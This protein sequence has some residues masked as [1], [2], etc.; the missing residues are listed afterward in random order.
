MPEFDRLL[1]IS[2]QSFEKLRDEKCVYVDKTEYIYRI[3]HDV[4]QYFLSRPRRFGKSL[5]LSTMR[6]YWKG[7]KELF[8][9]LAIE[10][11]EKNHPEAWV[12]HPV[13]YI[14]FNVDNYNEANT[15]EAVLDEHLREWEEEY[16]ITNPQGSY[17]IRFRKVIKTAH[18]KT[19]LRCV[20][21]VDEYDKPLLDLIDA[22]ELQ[23]HA[24]SV[25]K[26]FFSALK[27]RDEDIQS[28]FITGVSKFHK[29][30]IF[31]DLNQLRD[32][33]L[34]EEFSGICGITES[35][36]S[37][38]F[39]PEIKAMAEK[40]QIS[41]EE[42][43]RKLKQQYDGYRFHQD[44][45]PVYNPFSVINALC[46]KEFGSY[47]FESGT[48]TFL[49]KQLRAMEFDARRFT[50]HTIYANASLLKDY[51]ADNP[52]PIPLLYQTGYLTI[53][54]YDAEGCEYTL[55]FPNHE[56]KYGFLQNLMPEYVT[57][58]GASSGLDIFTLR[59]YTNQGDVESIM[60]VLT[61]LFA[62]ITYTRKEDPF[63]HY[64]Q[65]VIYLVFTLLGQFAEC[66]MHTFSGRIDCRVQTR[67]YI[68]LFE[69]KRDESAE[70]AL[71]Q[72]D[73]KS[74]TLPFVADSRKLYKIGV[75]FDSEK[76]LLSEWKVES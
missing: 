60:R 46:D 18:E 44:G 33:S 3:V 5:L 29:V 74:Y 10:K 35:E 32:I 65:T 68:Y 70:K 27:N 54:D 1:P 34:N 55:A 15:L 12:K 40:R 9:G 72:I 76:R 42:C 56:V 63:E 17:G 59:R 58:C 6:A 28:I 23:Q 45:A 11:L 71:Q 31:S 66:E 64:F 49:V 20:I 36:L 30:S 7:Q 16:G 4:A 39:A 38:N 69:F 22:Y 53:A 37:S 50:D 13:F 2:V 51:S 57:D 62:R 14:D 19:G 75:S 67:K 43:L 47:W 8:S 26:G 52:D 24:K 25:L 41:E 21:L 73:D 61:A 48:P